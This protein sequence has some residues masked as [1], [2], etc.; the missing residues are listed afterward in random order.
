MI[1]TIIVGGLI[2]GVIYALVSLGYSLV[3]GILKFINFAHGDVYMV[4]AFVGLYI[5]STFTASPWILIPLTAVITGTLGFLIEK[6]AYKPLRHAS[7]LNSMITAIA[8]GTILQGVVL[9]TAGPQTRGFPTLFPEGS[10]D[11]GFAK[12]SAMQLWLLVIVA[13]L[14]IVLYWV[15]M[16]TNFGISMRAASENINQLNLV[17]INSNQV[18]SLT[19]VI[20]AALGGVAGVLAGSYFSAIFPY[21]GATGGIKAFVA[22]I[23]GGIG[24]LPGAVVGGL[25]MGISEVV[26]AAYLP[27][28]RDAVAFLLLIL[29]LLYRPQGLFGEKGEER[30]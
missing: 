28:Y 10:F 26:F 4:G 16:K 9:K 11:L 5:A 21:M 30:V 3:Y 8:V 27:S 18:I 7:R 25:I 12:I 24:N 20:G 23:I 2:L 22:A 19:F 6:L 17:G 1:S 13:V 29:I 14:L 15:V